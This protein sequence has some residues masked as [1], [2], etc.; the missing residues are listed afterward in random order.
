MLKNRSI[1][2]STRSPI[3][4]SSSFLS[5]SRLCLCLNL[6]LCGL[7]L[8]CLSIFPTPQYKEYFASIITGYIRFV[9][10]E[11]LRFRFPKGEV[12]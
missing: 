3:N 11:L 10:W 8:S 7:C 5:A 12:E 9:N 4:D 6:C 2:S 1:N